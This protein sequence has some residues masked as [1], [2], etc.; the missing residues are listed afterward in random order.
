MANT[1]ADHKHSL[2]FCPTFPQQQPLLITISGPQLQWKP[3]APPE[4]WKAG[5]SR[6]AYS[7]SLLVLTTFNQAFPSHH[8][9]A[10]NSMKSTQLDQRTLKLPELRVAPTPTLSPLSAHTAYPQSP[11][12]YHH[13]LASNSCRGPPGGSE[14]SHKLPENQLLTKGREPPTQSQV[15]PV[16]RPEKKQQLSAGGEKKPPKMNSEIGT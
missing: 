14:A 6:D 5:C 4:D 11:H 16:R 8:I 1:P 13:I 10:P 7:F 9:L 2:K 15:F 3:H 12:P